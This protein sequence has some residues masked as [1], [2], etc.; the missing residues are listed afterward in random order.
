M[1]TNCHLG[2]YVHALGQTVSLMATAGVVIP[3]VCVSQQQLSILLLCIAFLFVVLGTSIMQ[4]C[5]EN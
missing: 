5:C 1:A 4:L 2:F 3:F